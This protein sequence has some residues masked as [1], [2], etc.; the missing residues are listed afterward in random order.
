MSYEFHVFASHLTGA[1]YLIAISVQVFLKCQ[2]RSCEAPRIRFSHLT[3]SAGSALLQLFYGVLGGVLEVFETITLEFDA[4][5][6]AGDAD[7]AVG[8]VF[9]LHYP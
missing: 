1:V 2:I 3:S 5:E 8:Y 9:S 4:A 7:D 6:P